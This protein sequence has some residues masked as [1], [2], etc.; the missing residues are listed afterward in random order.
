MVN[1]LLKSRLYRSCPLLSLN[2][3]YTW[4]HQASTLELTV[5]FAFTSQEINHHFSFYSPIKGIFLP[6]FALNAKSSIL[7][8]KTRRL[9]WNRRK[10]AVSIMHE[11]YQKHQLSTLQK[12]LTTTSQKLPGMLFTS[13]VFFVLKNTLEQKKGLKA[14]SPL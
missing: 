10:D 3:A 7:Q 12:R 8:H 13:V 1:L 6:F 5:F 9:V 14:K 4:R 11:A 2:I